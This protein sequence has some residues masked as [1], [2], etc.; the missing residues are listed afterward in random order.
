MIDFAL[1]IIVGLVTWSVAS[2]GPWGAAM[3]CISVICSGLLAMN[4][5]E[6][7]AE[8]LA[9]MFSDP[10]WQGR[11]DMVALVGLFALLVTGFRMA[12][13]YFSPAYVD[14]NPALYEAGRWGLGLVTGYVTM[15]FL[16][17]ALH[18]SL[19]PREFAGFTPER[20]N[21]LTLLAPD[22]QWL[23]FTQ[24]ASEKGYRNGPGRIFDGPELERGNYPNK[25]WPSFPIRYADR[26]QRTGQPQAAPP[27]SVSPGSPQPGSQQ[28]GTTQPGPT[29]SF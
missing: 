10:E 11:M 1:L 16:L 20:K 12:S 17:T 4:F 21:L 7:T 18:T 19:L 29:P 28:P 25:I 26:R 6:P 13:D 23:G 27:P 22:K 8:L 3:I 9:G 5:F 24:Y 15:A 14:V 2:E